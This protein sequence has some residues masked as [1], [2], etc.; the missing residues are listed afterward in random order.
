VAF[1]V[2]SPGGEGMDIMEGGSSLKA[3]S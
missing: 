3:K 2:N 1:D